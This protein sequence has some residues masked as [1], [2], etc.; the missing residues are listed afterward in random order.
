MAAYR[1][2]HD[3]GASSGPV[4]GGFSVGERNEAKAAKRGHEVAPGGEAEWSR[5]ILKRGSQAFPAA[6]VCDLKTQA[7]A[8]ES[9]A[10][11]YAASYM[12]NFP[13][14]GGN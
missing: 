10:Q 6:E 3:R 9:E 7:Q 12:A 5:A 2:K 13:Q 1:M 4:S 11:S 8:A 14:T